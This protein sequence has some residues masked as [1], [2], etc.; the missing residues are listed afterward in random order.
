[1]TAAVRFND[2]NSLNIIE[3]DAASN[4]GVDDIRQ[5]VEQVQ[6]PPSRDLTACL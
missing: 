6:I 1:M 5:L 4:N 2:G 3:L